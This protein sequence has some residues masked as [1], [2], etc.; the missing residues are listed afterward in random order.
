MLNG[1]CLRFSMWSQTVGPVDMLCFVFFSLYYFPNRLYVIV[2][3]SL[4]CVKVKGI[5]S[6]MKMYSP[7]GQPRST[8]L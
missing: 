3:H 4:W 2:N 5:H 7:S 6:K 1:N 8:D